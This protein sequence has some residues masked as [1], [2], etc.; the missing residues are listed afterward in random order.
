MREYTKEEVSE[1][2]KPNDCWIIIDNKIYDVTKFLNEHPGGKKV[3]T[4]VGGK[5]ATEQFHQLHKSSILSSV[6]NNYLIGS[7]KQ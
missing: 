2:K 4:R 3:L 7:V 6:G 5:D 1:H